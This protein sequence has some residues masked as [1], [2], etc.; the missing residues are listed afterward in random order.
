MRKFL[1]FLAVVLVA[2]NGYLFYQ[3]YQREQA[4]IRAEQE[5][6]RQEELAKEQ[7]RQ[8]LAEKRAEFDGLVA[9]MK[10]A[11]AKGEYRKVR[12]LSVLAYALAKQYGFP[13][14]EIDDL[15]AKIDLIIYSGRLAK[16]EKK[17]ADIYTYY[18]VRSQLNGFPNLPALAGRIR[19][20]RTQ[21]YQNEYLV[22][23]DLAD[24]AAQAGM[25]GSD[26]RANYLLSTLHLGRALAVRR[27]SPVVRADSNREDAIMVSQRRLF[28]SYKQMQENS[29]PEK[30]YGNQ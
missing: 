18:Y 27:A 17:S 3:N 28:F 15:L 9:Q 23:L 21:T 5:R 30:L 7:Q 25:S 13:V 1:I 26:F 6:L 24:K 29:L 11:F 12:D 19:K 22:C 4:R 10:E 8:L 20:L 14:N 2:A 16:L